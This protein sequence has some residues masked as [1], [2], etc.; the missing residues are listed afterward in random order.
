MDEKIAQI[1]EGY[2]PEKSKKER[3]SLFIIRVKNGESNKM[4][5]SSFGVYNA[6]DLSAALISLCRDDQSF[7]KVILVTAMALSADIL[8]N[9]SLSKGEHIH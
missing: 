7:R 6:S 5:M 1:L 2:D 8:N 9:I 4:A 3:E